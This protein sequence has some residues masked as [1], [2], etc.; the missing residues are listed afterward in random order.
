MSNDI[1]VWIDSFLQSDAIDNIRA[2]LAAGRRNEHTSDD[3]LR[4]AWVAALNMIGEGHKSFLELARSTASE[5]LIRGLDLPFDLLRDKRFMLERMH[6]LG[7][8]ERLKALK[9]EIAEFMRQS[10][11]DTVKN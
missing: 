8:A 5:L 6:D 9:P 1:E 2:Y 10:T 7:L 3:D 4:L 11:T